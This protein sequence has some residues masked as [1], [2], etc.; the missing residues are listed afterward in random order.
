MRL[1]RIV[2]AGI[3]GAALASSLA[4]PQSQIIP[5][6]LSS[7]PLV[8]SGGTV[9]DVTDWGHSARDLQD[10]IVIVRD[11]RITDVGTMAEVSIPK[12]ARVIDC[13]GKFI[14]P[15]LVDGFAGMN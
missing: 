5:R 10:S 12:G 14:I 11:G 1:L 7:I 8:L 6:P 2:L 13:T 3:G 15:G 4:W 9:V